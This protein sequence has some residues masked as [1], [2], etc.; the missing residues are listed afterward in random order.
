MNPLIQLHRQIQ[1]LFIALLLACFAIPA[2][3]ER[4]KTPNR[5]E[6]IINRVRQVPCAGE[7]ADLCGELHV[8]FGVKESLGERLLSPV[9][10]KL[11]KGF[12]GACPDNGDCLVGFGKTTRRKYVRERIGIPGGVKTEKVN[13]LGVGTFKL[14]LLVKANPNPPGQGDPCPGCRP[15]RFGLLYTVT[16]KFNNNNKL[17]FFNASPPFGKV[18]CE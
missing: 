7:E 11:A 1:Y 10:V 6:I 5:K 14:R 3:G 8:K 18:D 16:Y 15:V 13:G 17:T 4:D 9:E 2:M 12:S